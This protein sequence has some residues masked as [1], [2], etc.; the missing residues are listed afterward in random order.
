[1]R[2]LPPPL[3]PPPERQVSGE[4]S[5]IDLVQDEATKNSHIERLPPLAAEKLRA[6]EALAGWV[7]T[8]AQPGLPPKFTLVGTDLG[9]SKEF[10]SDGTMFSEVVGTPYY[11]A[12]EAWYQNY[13]QKID[14]WAAGIVLYMLTRRPLIEADSL[15][16][17][18]D[19]LRPDF[20]PKPLLNKLARVPD[21]SASSSSSQRT[22]SEK[23]LTLLKGLLEPHPRLRI[24][25]DA[26]AD[27]CKEWAAEAR[28]GAVALD[29]PPTF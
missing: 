3:P 27:L 21:S 26:A 7:P 14:L 28:R 17:A 13:D 5:A 4:I 19:I 18:V 16:E 29:R 11:L 20:D 15:Q 1:M 12:P 24:G 2:T 23:A 6:C 9:L 25:V 22:I 10:S 8:D